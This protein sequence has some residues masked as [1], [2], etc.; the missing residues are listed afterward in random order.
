MTDRAASKGKTR[1]SRDQKDVRRE[2]KIKRQGALHLVII[3]H[4][5]STFH[6]FLYDT[7]S[8]L[9]G[10]IFFCS[11]L[12]RRDWGRNNLVYNK[13]AS[14]P[15]F[16]VIVATLL[17]SN[18]HYSSLCSTARLRRR[19]GAAVSKACASRSHPRSFICVHR[20]A[21]SACRSSP[22]MGSVWWL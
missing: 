6:E 14:L 21:F 4:L 7:T 19:I 15:C 8:T 3:V 11:L 9:I 1:A 12:G 17:A 13:T 10:L 16:S 5:H 2:G 20:S 18:H 22:V